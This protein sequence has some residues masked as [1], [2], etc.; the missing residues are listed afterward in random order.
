MSLTS[1][2]AQELN[3]TFSINAD[4]IGVSNKQVFQ[5]L[6]VALTEFLNQQQWTNKVYENQEK[7]DC[8]MTLIISSYSNTSFSGTL[9]V[10]A[11]RPVYGSNYKTPIFN[12]K[13]DAISFEYTEFEPLIYNASIYQSNLIS[14]MSY[15]AYMIIGLDADTFSL[16]GGEPYLKQAFDI[17]NLAQ[18]GNYSGWEPERNSLNRNLLVDL[19]LANGHRE[20]RNVLYGYHRL[21][22]D[23][24]SVDEISAKD[25]VLNQL[26]SFE[27]LYKRSQNSFLFRIFFDAK[28]DEIVDVFNSG[29]NVEVKDLKKML[30]KISATN[31]LKW[32][33]I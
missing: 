33:K 2:K 9:Q 27:N 28:S 17:V 11:V 32:E 19:I 20:Y 6:E 1:V 29:P 16:K 31:S 3:C 18:S 7:I 23:Q 22:M 5:T 8:G 13:D 15:Y 14:L 26:M 4:Q 25:E 10:N 21:G 12:F 30:N 24:F